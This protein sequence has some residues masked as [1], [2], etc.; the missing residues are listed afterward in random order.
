MR[1]S[2]I[3]LF[4]ILLACGA[5]CA[6]A[7]VVPAANAKHASIVVGGM[8]S[9]FQPDYQGDLS[10]HLPVQPVAHSSTFPLIGVGAYVDVKFNRWVQ[11]EAE[12]RWQRF[13]QYSGI[14]QDNYL[15][16]PR[17]PIHSIW[18]AEFYGKALAGFSTMSADTF[19]SPG[20]FTDIA[21]GGGADI[22]LTRRLSFR[23]FDV[24]YQYWPTW[25]NSTL[26]PYGASMGIGY[27]VF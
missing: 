9:I 23:A 6:S 16:G 18:K 22:R 13:N 26:S 25:G 21:V 12:G 17:I 15:L 10:T 19:S 7:Q 24:E 5:S 14:Y 2:A 11:I 4:L 27:R 3:A 20:R 1:P 8:A